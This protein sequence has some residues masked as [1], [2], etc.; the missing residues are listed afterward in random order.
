MGWRLRPGEPPNDAQRRHVMDARLVWDTWRRILTSDDLVKWVMYPDSRAENPN[1]LTAEEMAILADYAGTRK[2][3]ESNIGMYRRGLVR[4]ALGALDLVPLTRRLLRASGLDIEAVATEFARSTGY[5][6]YGPNFWRT[7]DGFVAYLTSLPEFASRAQQEVL[8]IDAATIALARRLGE[9][10]TELWPDGAAEVFSIAGTRAHRES[11][12][13]V[14]N[15]AAVVVSSCCD[16][17]AWIENPFDFDVGEEVEASPRHWLIYFPGAEAAREYAELSER[18]SRAF[19]L[20]RTPK[21]AAELSLALDGLQR[22]DVLAVIDSLAGLGVIVCEAD[23]PS[24][25]VEPAL[26]RQ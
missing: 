24:L 20:L 7:A 15:R 26:E 3:T 9:S 14:A 11:A 22:A 19:H 1:G 5:A 13:F 4:N 8:A 12:R 6:D 16:L 21:T 23:L 17:T 18:A 2:A 25:T 10:A